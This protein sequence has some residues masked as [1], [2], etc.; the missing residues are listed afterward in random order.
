MT[1]DLWSAGQLHIGLR[2]RMDS[3]FDRIDDRFTRVDEQAEGVRLDIR[4]LDRRLPRAG[5]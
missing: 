4:D 1:D 3:R 2:D 5:G